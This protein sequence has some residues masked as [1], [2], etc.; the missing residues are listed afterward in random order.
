M[1]SEFS[2]GLCNL[3]GCDSPSAHGAYECFTGFNRVDNHIC[4][5][6]LLLGV[7][8]LLSGVALF[9]EVFT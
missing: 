4:E 7:Q 3:A 1:Q 5:F 6:W 8:I 9:A 2:S